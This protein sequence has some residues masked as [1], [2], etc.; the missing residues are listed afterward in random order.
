MMLSICVDCEENEAIVV[1]LYCGECCDAMARLAEWEMLDERISEIENEFT[2]DSAEFSA[3]PYLDSSLTKSSQNREDRVERVHPQL[4][5]TRCK[6]NR[7]ENA[8]RTKARSNRGKSK[9][10]KVA[11]NRRQGTEFKK[12]QHRSED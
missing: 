2:S 7:N 5:C 11:E 6:P 3:E 12:S 9:K 4:S 1:D 8:S 10:K